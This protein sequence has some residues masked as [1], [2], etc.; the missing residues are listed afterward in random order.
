[1]WKSLQYM[2]SNTESD[3][4]IAGESY[5]GSLRVTALLLAFSSDEDTDRPVSRTRHLA[6]QLWNP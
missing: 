1:V 2:P 4:L 6:Q 5:G 3:R